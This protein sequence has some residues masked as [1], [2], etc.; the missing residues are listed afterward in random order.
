MRYEVKRPVQPKESPIDLALLA[1]ILENAA[2]FF[3]KTK[4][5][6]TTFLV[7]LN[8]RDR[9]LIGPRFR[10]YRYK[11]GP[12]SKELL[13]AY[14]T[15]WAHGL[16]RGYSL[17]D[18]GSRLVRFINL[19]KQEPDNRAFF[20]VIDPVLKRCQKQHGAQLMEDLCELR[21]RPEGSTDKI[22]LKDIQM[23]TDI[24]VPKGE[25]SLN[26]STEMLQAIVD[27]LEITDEEIARAE[28][29]WPKTEVRAL[30]RLQAAISD[31]QLEE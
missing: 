12:F 6:K 14:E 10:F 25:P 21:V 3:G 5:Q 30:N 15:L 13:Q 7:E 19:L 8:L 1:Y 11:N 18:R 29:D 27:E 26:I 22:V 20:E 9:E 28:R 2:P 23:G 17:T 24:I 4:L 16:A 31:D